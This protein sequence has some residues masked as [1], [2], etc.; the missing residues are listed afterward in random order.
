M[1]LM[2]NADAKIEGFAQNLTSTSNFTVG[3]AATDSTT[4]RIISLIAAC[5]A[6]PTTFFLWIDDGAGNSIYLVNGKTIAA[7][8]IYQIKD[9]EVPL[10]NGW[11]YKCKAGAA[12]NIS[13]TA[14]L[15]RPSK[16]TGA[17]PAK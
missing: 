2:T 5:N 12:N 11:Q 13:V 1:S 8:D 7:N 6:T 17:S 3:P 10:K 16:S 4:V 14:S 9:H 15:A